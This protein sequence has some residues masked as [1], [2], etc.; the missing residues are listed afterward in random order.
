MK[1]METVAVQQ[2]P[3]ALDDLS[4]FRG[5]WVALR[6]GRVVGS[7]QDPLTLF[8]DAS[9]NTND[10]LLPVPSTDGTLII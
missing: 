7:A 5:Q 9:F 1:N 6:E 8:E 2:E 4:P 3:I 10:V